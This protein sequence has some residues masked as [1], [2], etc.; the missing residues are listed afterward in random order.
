MIIYCFLNQ[1]SDRVPEEEKIFKKK[2]YIFYFG[3]AVQG[4]G[5]SDGI[6]ESLRFFCGEMFQK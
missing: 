3:V 4:G 6:D 1:E 5:Q 2:I